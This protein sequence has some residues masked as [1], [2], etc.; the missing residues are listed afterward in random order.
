MKNP[1]FQDEHYGQMIALKMKFAV[2]V[3]RDAAGD[4]WQM[5]QH[6]SWEM[7]MHAD[8]WELM[9]CKCEDF[10]SARCRDFEDEA[11]IRCKVKFIELLEKKLDAKVVLRCFLG[12]VLGHIGKL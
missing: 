9:Q 6:K 3:P 1:K 4:E 7:Q 5:L 10:C 2:L 12:F 8:F 11:L